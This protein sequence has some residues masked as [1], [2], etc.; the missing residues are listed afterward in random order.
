MKNVV[1]TFKEW[2]EKNSLLDSWTTFHTALGAFFC[3]IGIWLG[4]TTPQ[5]LLLVLGVALLW[6]VFEYAVENWRP[7]GTKTKWMLNTISDIVA[8]MSIAIWMVI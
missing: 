5:I 6:E 1:T 2:L 3:K 8:A 4:L 7:Y